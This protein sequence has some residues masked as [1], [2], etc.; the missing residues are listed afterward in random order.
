MEKFLSQVYFIKNLGNYENKFVA[1]VTK[2]EKNTNDG[3][4]GKKQKTNTQSEQKKDK[5]LPTNR[6]I[7]LTNEICFNLK[8][9]IF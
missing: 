2:V 5:N 6:W 4:K 7:K 8:Y 9:L 3:G 1:P